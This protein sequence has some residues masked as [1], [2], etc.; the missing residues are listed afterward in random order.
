MDS[1]QVPQKVIDEAH[2]VFNRYDTDNSNSIEKNELRNLL[3]DLSK[4]IGIPM[5]S[6]ED[7]EQVMYDVDINKDK[8]L[9]RDEFLNLFKIIYQMKELCKMSD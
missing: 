5:P 1:I 6:D 3:S 7:V 4:E 9:S 8:R 2:S